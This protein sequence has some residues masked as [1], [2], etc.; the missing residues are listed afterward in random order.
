LI[1]MGALITKP[2][3]KGQVMGGNPAQ[4]IAR[5]RLSSWSN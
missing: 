5:R 1:A 2:V 4:E 3:K